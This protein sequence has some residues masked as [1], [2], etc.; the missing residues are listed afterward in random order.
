MDNKTISNWI[1]QA[2]YRAKANQILSDL[3]ITDVQN[4]ITHFEDK[5]AYCDQP[6]ETLDH[7]FPLKMN[8]P[9]IPANILPICR[10]CKATKKNHDVVWMYNNSHITQ[11]EYLE[12]M[13]FILEQRGGDTIKEHVRRA[14]GI[15]E[16]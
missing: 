15:I 11:R 13:R 3:E 6:A 10:E 8:A 5:C 1:R 14:T 16:E 12:I 7:P 9:N 2:R 4:I